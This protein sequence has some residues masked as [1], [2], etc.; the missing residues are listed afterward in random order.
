MKERTVRFLVFCFLFLAGMSGGP[1]SA[2]KKEIVTNA[3]VIELM[4]AK[5]DEAVIVQKIQG[6]NTKF[7][8][9]VDGL[10]Q[11]KKAGVS[12]SIIQSM[13]T[14]GT[15]ANP[16]PGSHLNNSMSGILSNDAGDVFIKENGK[17][18]EMEYIA[19]IT[20]NLT[21]VFL[22]LNTAT[23]F[24][25][26]ADGARASFRASSS[27]PS[28]LVKIHPSQMSIVKFDFDTYQKKKVRY[29][30]RAG[31]LFQTTGGAGGPGVSNID[32]N[33]KRV[34]G[35]VY[36]ITLKN[37]LEKGEYGIIAPLASSKGLWAASSTYKIY[38]FG[39][40]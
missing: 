39:I 6:S 4:K 36:K 34:K 33:F 29:V 11:L 5:L 21:S 25:I 27:N 23:R 7:D 32:F 28:F 15:D 19:G 14:A 17:L 40:D 16:N 35:K 37:P 10:I 8:L 2:E 1:A 24:A 3:M 31:E 18:V 22:L 13:I 26:I 12:D 30:V 20:K 9:S 38:E